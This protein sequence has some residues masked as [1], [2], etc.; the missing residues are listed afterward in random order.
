[1]K[2][3]T[4]H[5]SQVYR[6]LFFC[7]FLVCGAYVGKRCEE[8]L[9]LYPDPSWGLE[10]RLENINI[11]TIRY[12][13]IL[14]SVHT[15]QMWLQL[16]VSPQAYLPTSCTG[17]QQSKLRKEICMLTAT[18]IHCFIVWLTFDLLPYH[19]PLLRHH[20]VHVFCIHLHLCVC[21]CLHLSV[22]STVDEI[23]QTPRLDVYLL[24]ECI[25]VVLCVMVALRLNSLPSYGE[26]YHSHTHCH[27]CPHPYSLC[28]RWRGCCCSGRP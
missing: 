16:L 2:Q 26:A 13:C 27:T 22:V 11:R 14:I 3:S 20:P 9:V 8:H 6:Q 28:Q 5:F 24:L 7:Y 21:T 4:F 23:I 19:Y 25:V 15:G 1:M 12:A 17:R 18:P 10:T